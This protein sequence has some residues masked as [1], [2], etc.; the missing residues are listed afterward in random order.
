MNQLLGGP[1]AETATLLNLTTPEDIDFKREQVKQNAEQC[2]KRDICLRKT[3][4][5]FNCHNGK[6]LLNGQHNLSQLCT[7]N[8]LT[9]LN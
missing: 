1:R 4:L 6:I 5:L 8:L 7:I 3:D 2:I 9:R